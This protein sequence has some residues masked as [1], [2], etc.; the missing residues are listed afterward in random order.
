MKTD[1]YHKI[2]HAHQEWMAALDVVEYPI[3]MHDREFRILR[4]NRAYQR[5]SGLPFNE[6]IGRPYYDLLPKTGAP[7]HHCLEALAHPQSEAKEE[8]VDVNGTLF[9]SRSYSIRN[10]EGEY[11]YS[12]HTLEDIT[13]K[14]KIERA[15]KESEEKFRSITSSAQD[16]IV[17]M[18]ETGNI[19]YWNRAAEKMFGYTEDEALG[20][21][22]HTFITPPRYL[23]A[24]QIGYKHFLESGEGAVVGK[25]VDLSALKK[26]G[27]E[28]PIGLSLSAVKL[29]KGW[30]AIGIIRD[31]SERNR[32]Q[33]LLRQSEEKFRA[34]VESTSDWIW[35][36]DVTGRY[37]YVSPRVETLLGFTPDEVIGKS[38]FDLMPPEE[39]ARVANEFGATIAQRAPILGMEN[40]NICKD[41]TRKVLETSGVPFFD[42][43]GNFAG[44]RGIDRDVTNRIVAE[45]NLRASEERYRSL[46]ETMLNGFAYCQILYD[47]GRPSDFIYLNVNKA[48][49][50]QTK[51]TNVTGKRVSEVIPGILESDPELLARYARVAGGGE[52]EQFEIYLQSMDMW[53]FISIYSPKYSYFVAIFDVITERKKAEVALKNEVLRR[54]LLMENSRDGIA[55]INK[56]F[57]IIETNARL[58]E[59]LGYTPEEMLNLHVWDFEANLDKETIVNN[60]SDLVH[61]NTTIETQHRRKNGTLYDAEVSINGMII[62]NE[63]MS[64]SITRDITERKRSEISLSRANR[65]LKTLS[66][67]NMAL[68]R[69]KDENELLQTITDII[70]EQA[71]YS[72]AAVV[73]AE[74]NDAKS[75]SF[76]AGSGM[77]SDTHQWAKDITW[78]DTPQ[79]QLPVSVAIRTGETQVCHNIACAIGFDPWKESARAQGYASNIALPLMNG[80]K[81]FG[82][83]CIYS[84]EKNAFDESEIE[85]LEEL[86][87]DLGYGIINLRTRVAH[88]QQAAVLRQSLEESIQTIAATVE[89]RD[90]Y[91]AGHQRRVAELARAIASEMQLDEE[92]IVGIHFAAI[93][94][95]LG[96][97]H[98]PA[99]ILSKPGRLNEIEFM[100]IQTH[101]Q[102][103]YNIIK[104][105]HFPWP[106]AETILQHHEKLDGSGYP[107]GLKGDEIRIEARIITVADVM[108]A[109]SSHRPYRAALGL[110][111]ALKEILRGRGLQ[112]DADVVDACIRLFT[113]KDFQFNFD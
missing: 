29:E 82:A 112:Y 30:N 48:F 38:P 12:L 1:V 81:T 58:S 75:I 59:M 20:K 24:H 100:L 19:S 69:L 76:M 110:D 57:K 33:D 46:F 68:V 96:K 43:A 108:E 31:N 16:A 87:N 66:A 91:T 35:E 72:M 89:A 73:Y 93:I 55:V 101:S 77:N 52:P 105:V 23:E 40:T 78:G 60:F 15:L 95:D 107:N 103:G 53:F 104:D 2:A 80:D 21:H 7:L 70:I 50:Q 25:T 39:A 10:E 113:E 65:A 32:T 84:I 28:F 37:T 4:C 71:G 88:E 102:E 17:M 86:A 13:L 18:D 54:Q 106:I 6:I 98:I 9:L 90:P 83:L 49:E 8:E 64:F 99:E 22:L 94:H 45:T 5:Y 36:V 14:R 56:E 26:G 41:G 47:E 85:L 63:P 74:E 97:I 109:M 92:Q 51:L 34:L 3:F 27:E 44:Y 62:N 61:V 79:G 67:G 42:T 11:L 111:P